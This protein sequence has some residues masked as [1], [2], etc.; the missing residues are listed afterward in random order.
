MALDFSEQQEHVGLIPPHWCGELS[1]G[2]EYEDQ[3]HTDTFSVS[4][5]SNQ[6]QP[7]RSAITFSKDETLEV[8]SKMFDYLLRQ[9][10]QEFEQ[11]SK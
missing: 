6:T 8:T 11:N 1:A 4:T 5:G 7:D 3:S 9:A 10:V 2:I